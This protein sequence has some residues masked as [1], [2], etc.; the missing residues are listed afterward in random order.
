MPFVPKDWRNS[1]DASTPL[2]A[3]ALENLETRLSAYTDILAGL[4]D[5]KGD[6]ISASANDTPGRLPVGT[7]NH[8]LTADSAQPLGIKWAAATG[9]GGGI[10]ATIVDAKGDLIAASAND[11]VVRLPVGSNN[12]VLIADS[13]QTAG[14]R[15]GSAGAGISGGATLMVAASN[16]PQAVKDRA[17]FVC[18]GVDDE[19]Q[20]LAAANA[21]GAQ[22]VPGCV[23]LSA[24]TFTFGTTFFPNRVKF[25]LKGQGMGVTRIQP[26]AGF[27]AAKLIDT[28]YTPAG[29]DPQ[30]S[31]RNTIKDLTLTGQYIGAQGAIDGLWFRSYRGR[32]ENVEAQAFSGYGIVDKGVTAAERPIA[33]NGWNNYGTELRDNRV[34]GNGLGGIFCDGGSTDSK[35][36]GGEVFSNAGPGIRVIGVLYGINDMFIW[37]NRD[38]I[39]GTPGRGIVVEAGARCPILGNKIE[40]NRGGI[41]LKGPGLV[42]THIIAHN[43]FSSNSV[44]TAAG[45]AVSEDGLTMPTGWIAAGLINEEDDILISGNQFKTLV[46]DN[47]FKAAYPPDTSQYNIHVLGAGGGSAITGNILGAGQTGSIGPNSFVSGWRVENNYG[48]VTENH[49]TATIA[50]GSTSISVAHGL[51]RTPSAQ[52]IRLQ[53]HAS[54]AT[55][56][57]PFINGTPTATNFTIAVPTAPGGSGL[58]VG[59]QMALGRRA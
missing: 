10:L 40:Q 21:F 39:N 29:G 14:L 11:A 6:L 27:T 44:A 54:T 34:W 30:P 57:Q 9:G 8:V 46:V 47:I 25:V 3:E 59:W 48:Y 22:T 2:S 58:A 49:G 5:A 55:S 18:D 56:G 52:D 7:N 45:A 17:D 37:G 38:N 20:V 33:N 41:E 53:P 32:V 50:S 16:A 23:E 28:V 36:T 12:Q 4:L 1:P 31:P 13:T 35:L 42:E 26:K 15:W 24:G 51:D 19:V 43:I